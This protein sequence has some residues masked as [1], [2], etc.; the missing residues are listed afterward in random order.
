MFQNVGLMAVYIHDQDTFPLYDSI[1]TQYIVA[2]SY[3]EVN[4]TYHTVHAERLEPPYD[5]NCQK[6]PRKLFQLMVNLKRFQ[7]EILTRFKKLTPSLMLQEKDIPDNVTLFFS[8][9]T[10]LNRTLSQLYRQLYHEH[11]SKGRSAC[12]FRCTVSKLSFGSKDHLL[13]RVAWPD[14]LEVSIQSVKKLEV[15]D[16]VIYIC[17]CIGIWF[18]VSI[19]TL[20]G[21]I[22]SV[23]LKSINDGRTN[24]GENRTEQ[25]LRNEMRKN[26]FI[27]D[28]RF[29]EINRTFQRMNY[30]VRKINCD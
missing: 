3:S 27:N 25:S 5:T 19:Y 12:I 21:Y 22:K 28:R 8:R 11:I 16:Y 2:T 14:G 26:Q 13:F 20:F 15:I 6:Y 4:P 23:L 30:R 10:K 18:G 7:E 9:D 17:S 1:F 29:Q 24:S